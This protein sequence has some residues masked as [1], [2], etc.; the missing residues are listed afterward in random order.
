[1]I[2]EFSDISLWAVLI[3]AS[4]PFIVGFL[5]YG[6]VFGKAWQK[7]AGLSDKDLKNAPTAQVFGISFLANL[8][9]VYV[10]AT[11]LNY[12]QFEL[13]AASGAKAG[14]MIGIAFQAMML[15]T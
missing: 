1:M 2:F 8:V 11:L 6:P 3:A 15:A 5:W 4:V 9:M 12:N 13:D 14:L 10:L 7:E